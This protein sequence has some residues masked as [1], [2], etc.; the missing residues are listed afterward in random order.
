[1]V[2]GKG[3]FIFLFYLHL[4]SPVFPR[5]W[6]REKDLFRRWW[7]PI[8][9]MGGLVREYVHTLVGKGDVYFYFS[10]LACFRGCRPAAAAA[11]FVA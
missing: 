9:T 8:R 2:E 6:L 1:M 11:W 4:R 7:A 5:Q 10:A 3:G